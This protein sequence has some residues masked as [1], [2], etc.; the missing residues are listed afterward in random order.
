MSAI[1]HRAEDH[2]FIEFTDAAVFIACGDRVLEVQPNEGAIRNA[3]AL[4]RPSA[5]GEEIFCLI[6]AKGVSI[7]KI[8]VPA[9]SNA[10]V[11]RLL[12]MQIDTHFP[13][14]ADELAWGYAE[15][16]GG[17]GTM[18]ELMV[19]A[20]RKETLKPYQSLLA[21]T[22]LQPRFVIAALARRALIPAGVGSCTIV[23]TSGSRWE[24]LQE[25]GGLPSV[26]LIDPGS[27]LLKEGAVYASG[28]D[29]AKVSAT[30]LPGA[31]PTAAIAGLRAMLR[32][33][34]AP[35]ALGMS[36]QGFAAKQATTQWRWAA[37]AVGL[38]ILALAL[39]V[40]E[41]GIRQRH[42]NSRI[43]ELKAHQANLPKL[44]REVSF[45][46]YLKTN[47]P[48]YL[49]AVLSVATSAQ[50]IKLDNLSISRRGELS[51]RGQMQ[52]A[53]GPS[54]MRSKLLESGYFSLVTI[55]EQ[56]PVPN[57]QQVNFRLTALLRSQPERPVA[58]SVAGEKQKAV[59]TNS[60]PSATNM[61]GG[62]ASA[63]AAAQ[64]PQVSVQPEAPGK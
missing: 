52:G 18:K 60:P 23:D 54:Q 9:R 62:A 17:V 43:K 41:P 1:F 57:Q 53:Q 36:P 58:S 2:L 3:V 40:A 55:D 19:A 50:G 42:V 26:R 32:R 44:E 22:G 21:E 27:P 5:T 64:P 24:M 30:L 37:T 16:P 31:T 49:D 15:L 4:L 56:T 35:L 13:I 10:D 11:E 51:L 46:Q 63:M 7:R 12:P 33:G 20:V 34:E 28:R 61:A 38:A 8:A 39:R 47:Q 45:L 6:P 29:A 48:S 14:S 25:T 59:R